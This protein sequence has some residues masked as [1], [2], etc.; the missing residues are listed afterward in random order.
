MSLAAWKS[1]GSRLAPGIAPMSE[2]PG[3]VM[4]MRQVEWTELLPLGA[5]KRRAVG[6]VTELL[7]GGP[8]PCLSPPEVPPLAV[9]N[10]MLARPGSGGMNGGRRW[11]RF[12][13][14]TGDYEA[15]VA[16][17][18]AAHGYAVVDV[19]AWLE[20]LDDWHAWIMERR[21]AVPAEPQRLLNQRARDLE[22]QLEAARADATTAPG[23]MA[24]LYL[25]AGRARDDAEHFMDPWIMMPRFSK[26]RRASR[27][28]LDARRRQK[29]AQVAGD[30]AGVAA[31]VAEARIA[32]ERVRSDLADDEWP[33]AWDG[34]WPEYPPPE[35]PPP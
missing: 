24:T 31:A 4:P 10:Q 20:G 28:L 8:Y 17:L 27:W 21:R 23:R 3:T 5:G 26:Y 25:Q 35:A 33:A 12:A 30:T 14:S 6:T 18:V 11:R 13:L 9:V 2:L 16:D 7:V 15:L 34:D 32:E 1:G 22:R 29:A 19:P